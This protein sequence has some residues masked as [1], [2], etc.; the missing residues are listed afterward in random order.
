VKILASYH[1]KGGVGKSTTAVNLSFLAAREGF[2]TL[3]WDL[4]PQGSAS[5]YFRIKPRVKGGTRGLLKGRRR[6]ED[7]LR[8]TDFPRLDLLPADFSYRNL[9]LVLNAHKKPFKVLRRLLAPLKND[10]DLVVLDCPPGVS[11]S[12][13]AVLYAAD[14]LLIPVIPTTLSVE[15]L[16]RL[17][18]FVTNKGMLTRLRVCPF[19]SMVD[20]RRA[21][22][23]KILDEPPADLGPF[24]SAW[25]PYSSPVEQMGL[26]RAPLGA[27][28]G[29]TRA[30]LAYE[31]LWGETK[32]AVFV[33]PR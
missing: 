24:L 23:R 17:L 2:R 15:T 30:A 13:L 9:D 22:H 14:V 21:L 19:F 6:L 5:F 18:G 27:Y 32:A 8:G 4:D 7:A 25:I 16:R 12:S 10:Y 20:R 3:L 29:A 28:G 1:I 11:L 31:D 33:P 26:R